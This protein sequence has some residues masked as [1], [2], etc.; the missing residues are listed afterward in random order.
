MPIAETGSNKSTGTSQTPNITHGLTINS[1]DKVVIT[2][3]ANASGNVWSDNNGSTPL[4]VDF[5]ETGSGTNTYA[6][7]SRIAG[8][9]EPANY[10]F[11]LS[12]SSQAWSIIIRVFSG[13]HASTMWNVA[14][15]AGTRASGTGTTATSPN[16]TT[17]VA[18]AMGILFCSNDTATTT[19]SAPTNGYG[20][21]V[22]HHTSRT[23]GS[24]IQVWPTATTVGTAAMTLS[25]SQDWMIH[26]IALEPAAA[27]GPV[28]PVFMAQYRKRWG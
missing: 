4:T 15:A 18:G 19:L 10:T 20:T 27:G 16:M 25:A 12:G 6:I 22:E 14:P 26:Q 7:M 5:G 28:I 23:Q 21:L 17:T 9:S 11:N 3:N 2:G 1:G 8:A 24:A 13:G